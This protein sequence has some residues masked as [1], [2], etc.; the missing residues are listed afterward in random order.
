MERYLGNLPINVYIHDFTVNVGLPEHLEEVAHQLHSSARPAG[1]FEDFLESVSRAVRAS[2]GQL[3]TIDGRESFEAA[4]G[5]DEALEVK[6]PGGRHV[7]ERDDLRALWVALSNG[8]VTR[9]K[10][11][12]S[13]AEAADQVL[14]VMSVLPGVRPVQIQQ[15]NAAPEIA[16][17]LD[18]PKAATKLERTGT[19]RNFEWA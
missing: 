19:Q 5:S 12:W 6:Q 11:L 4:L 15:R 13:A 10:A 17:E 9:E 14:S 1:S 8:L 2:Q 16:L 7:I 3:V 18:A